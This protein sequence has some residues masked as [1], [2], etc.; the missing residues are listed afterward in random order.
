MDIFG[1]KSTTRKTRSAMHYSVWLPL[2]TF[3]YRI[4]C[5]RCSKF[6]MII[7]F[8]NDS[9]L[10]NHKLIIDELLQLLFKCICRKNLL[11]LKDKSYTSTGQDGGVGTN[12]SPLTISDI[13]S[14]KRSASISHGSVCWMYKY[15]I[16]FQWGKLCKNELKIPYL[17]N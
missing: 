16:N 5:Y 12:I 9:K 10:Y 4:T 8:I 14:V 2:I 6:L 13:I 11:W 17:K 1:L 15:L 7:S 3:I